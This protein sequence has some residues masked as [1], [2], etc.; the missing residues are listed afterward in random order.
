M[1]MID[2]RKC[3]ECGACVGVCPELALRLIE[4]GIHNN[5]ELCSACSLCEKICPIGAITVVKNDER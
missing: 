4:D 3:L 1:W 2:R 5:E